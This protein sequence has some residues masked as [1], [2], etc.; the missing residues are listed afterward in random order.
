MRST[1]AGALLPVPIH[2]WRRPTVETQVPLAAKLP[3]FTG[4]TNE[5]GGFSIYKLVSVTTPPPGDPKRLEVASA[6]LGEQIGRELVNAYVASLKSR[7]DVK[8]N[9]QALEKGR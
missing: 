2:A 8:I 4:S 6:R 7:A 1:R 5:R 9:Q 3:S